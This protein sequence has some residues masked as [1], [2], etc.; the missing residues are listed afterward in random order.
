MTMRVK[1][2]KTL[3]G[4]VNAHAGE[5]FEITNEAQLRDLLNQ[6][7]VVPVESNPQEVA[8]IHNLSGSQLAEARQQLNEQELAD[9]QAYAEAVQHAANQ[10][11][12]QVA[13]KRQEVSKQAKQQAEQ[14][15]QQAFQ[16]EQSLREAEAQVEQMRQQVKQDQ[17][18]QKAQQKQQSAQR[19]QG[20]ATN[21]SE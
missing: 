18:I 20:Q 6:G 13:Q 14:K 8:K 7:V 11:V 1:A 17:A 12:D 2:L 3:G 16:Q 5:E 15:A 10:Q 21:R 9:S 19:N 4:A